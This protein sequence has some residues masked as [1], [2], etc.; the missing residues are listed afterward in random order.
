MLRPNRAFRVAS[1]K[2]V[3]PDGMVGQ[4]TQRFVRVHAAR[5]DDAGW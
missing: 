4:S 3:T 2:N 5:Q 1:P